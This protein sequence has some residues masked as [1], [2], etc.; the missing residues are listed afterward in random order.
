MHYRQ[1]S[2]REMGCAASTSPLNGGRAEKYSPEDEPK[3]RTFQRVLLDDIVNEESYQSLD[4]G[5]TTHSSASSCLSRPSPIS[6]ALLLRGGF[7]HPAAVAAAAV[8][9]MRGSEDLRAERSKQFTQQEENTEEDGDTPPPLLPEDP[10][11]RGS[12]SSQGLSPADSTTG[13]RELQGDVAFERGSELQ[14]VQQQWQERHRQELGQAERRE[15]EWRAQQQKLEQEAI[16]LPI[17]DAIPKLQQLAQKARDHARELEGEAKRTSSRLLCLHERE[18]RIKLALDDVAHRLDI[19]SPSLPPL[20]KEYS[21][22]QEEAIAD[23]HA[24]I[25]ADVQMLMTVCRD[26]EGRLDSVL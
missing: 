3:Q 15:R 9:A 1:S 2:I 12:P 26:L 19:P 14:W 23:H 7:A 4:I 8:V 20:P 13:T 25:R 6:P 10:I 17:D 11:K 16:N 18:E 22:T 21:S 24:T 5:K